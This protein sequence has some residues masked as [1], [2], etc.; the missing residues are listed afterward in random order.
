MPKSRKNEERRS[1]PAAA[2]VLGGFLLE[3]RRAGSDRRLGRSRHS[4]SKS[5]LK[6]C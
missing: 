4:K 2:S 3:D 1:N 6:G 5:R